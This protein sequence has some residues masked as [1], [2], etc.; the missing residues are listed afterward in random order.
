MFASN[1]ASGFPTMGPVGFPDAP[2]FPVALVEPSGGLASI[3]FWLG[4]EPKQP[5]AT[6]A[7]ERTGR[8]ETINCFFMTV[9]LPPHRRGDRDQVGVRLL[10]PLIRIRGKG[11]G[12]EEVA[13]ILDRH[14]L[15]GDE[16]R[17]DDGAQG[18]H[19]EVERAATRVP[20]GARVGIVEIGQTG[21]DS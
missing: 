17:A 2:P 20:G 19:A 1:V 6:K 13:L 4:S 7:S 11:V 3:E 9:L 5:A 18:Q 16:G 12:T 10:D 21:V 15:V 8:A 14:R